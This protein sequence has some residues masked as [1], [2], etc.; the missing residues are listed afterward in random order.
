MKKSAG[1]VNIL[2][3]A[4][5]NKPSGEQKGI[6]YWEKINGQKSSIGF[7]WCKTTL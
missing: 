3:H 2:C 4:N 5:A 7:E 6:F 1:N